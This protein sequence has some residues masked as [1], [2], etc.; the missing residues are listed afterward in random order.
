MKKVGLLFLSVS[1]LLLGACGNSTAS[2]DGKLNIVTT[3]YPVYE[4][5]KQV[6]GDE[7]NVDLLVKAGTE[8]H[9]YEPSAKDIARIQEADAFFY[10]NEN[11][12][13]WVH[14]VE[15]SLD[16]TKVNV[17]SATEGMLLLPGGE[18]EHEGH[19]HSGDGHSHAYD[20]HV[21]LSP[22]R[23]ITLVENIRD[24]L[25]AKYPEKKD[26]FET[27]AA[28]YIEKL[29]ALDAK[30]SETLSAAKQKYFVTQ[31]TAFA[32]LALDYG[33][34]QVSIT[35]VAADEDPTPSRLAELTEY[36]NKYGIKYIYFE[37]NAS[38]SVAETL[39]K[40]TGVQLDVLN[41]L[42]SLTDED[43]KNGKDYISVMEDNLTA[44]EKT[45]SQ[46]GSEILPEEGAETTQTVYNGYFEDSAVKDRTLSDY[47]GE[48]QSV[49]P[50]LLDGTLDQV[51][52]YK[53]KI[54][55][56]MTAEEYKAYYDTGYKTDVDQIN[57]TDNTMEFVVGDKKEKFTYKYVGYKILT[58]KKGNR[59]VRFLF[60]ATD[61]NAGN[62]KYVQFS[63]HNIAPV[64]T[65]HFHI[66]FGG[67]S[68][69]KLLEELE[70]WPTYYPVGLTGL[71][72]GQEMLAH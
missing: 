45:T 60:E 72:I 63:D 52:D 41:P 27:N 68:Q 58:Y 70:N 57:I 71:E 56:G 47:A 67:E 69:E 44:L 46:E 12:E 30:Y 6:V 65:G 55:G 42:E 25:V 29:D 15:K 28:A 24:S 9:G 2:E 51:W 40:E 50:Y 61:A 53:A 38:K 37:E 18:E 19:D 20:P 36:I 5:T 54:K 8:V 43:M 17:I 39:A 26:A 16:T 3:F 22:E 35:G 4:F 33:L 59:G 14:D 21:W 66:Y 62:Y 1:A 23:A 7:A 10:E 32:Y 31:H 34:K 49:Y 48:W 64:K 11:M 13:T